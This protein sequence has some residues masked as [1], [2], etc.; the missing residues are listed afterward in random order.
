LTLLSA[1]GLLRQDPRLQGRFELTLHCG[2]T[3]R[4]YVQQL[5]RLAEQ[6]GAR[7]AGPYQ[8][9]RLAEVLAELDLLVV[10]SIWVE[11]QPL[12]IREAFAAHRPVVASRLGALPESVRDGVDGLLF[13]PGDAPDLARVLSRLLLEP[14]LYGQLQA[15]LPAIKSS[16]A[17]AQELLAIYRSLGAD[18]G[19]GVAPAWSL[20]LPHLTELARSEQALRAQPLRALFAEVLGGLEAWGRQFGVVPLSTAALLHDAL[21]PGGQAEILLGDQRAELGYLR[22]TLQHKD[23]EIAVRMEE[24]AYLRG[25]L[26]NARAEIASLNAYARGLEEE[27]RRER[28][29][30]DGQIENLTRERDWL[31]DVR[32]QLEAAQASS[33]AELAKSQA[34]WAQSQATLSNQAAELLLRRSQEQQHVEAL[35]RLEGHLAELTQYLAQRHQDLATHAEPSDRLGLGLSAAETRAGQVAAAIRSAE[36][37]SGSI[38]ER[39]HVALGSPRSLEWEAA[40]GAAAEGDS[41]LQHIEGIDLGL[42]QLQLELLW[43]RREMEAMA[44]EVGAGLRAWLR[45]GSSAPV[46][47]TRTWRAAGQAIGAASAVVPP[48]GGAGAKAPGGGAP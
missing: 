14:E 46:Q 22:A 19:P 29:W 45:L 21:S 11:N 2:S 47:R 6:V 9:E 7:W 41:M 44:A 36:A 38:L 31:R 4:V 13:E 25:E 33:Q 43:R 1:I 32:A 34:E 20:E 16:D 17:Q 12:V 24:S 42:E 27:K 26:E 48:V 10:P 37:R 8:P 23:R 5:E 28:A 15:N 3:D 30:L 40:R 35:A 39:I 18:A